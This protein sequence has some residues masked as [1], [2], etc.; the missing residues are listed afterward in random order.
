MEVECSVL[1]PLRRLFFSSSWLTW[2]FSA[3]RSCR[4]KMLNWSLKSLW[5]LCQCCATSRITWR[6]MAWCSWNREWIEAA[7][8]SFTKLLTPSV[9]LLVLPFSISVINRLL[10]TH[11]MPCVL[12]QLVDCCPWMSYTEGL[13]QLRHLLIWL[14]EAKPDWPPLFLALPGGE[15]KKYINGKWQ[16]IPVED[17]LKMTK[18]DGQVWICLYNLLLKEDCQRKYDFNSFNKNQLLKVLLNVC[19]GTTSLLHCLCVNWGKRVSGRLVSIN[20][21]KLKFPRVV[22][23][24][25]LPPI[26]RFSPPSGSIHY[27][28]ASSAV[29]L[30]PPRRALWSRCL[31]VL[32][33]RGFLTEVLIDQLPVLLEL[34]RFLAHLAITD[35]APPK[36]GLTLEL[37]HAFSAFPRMLTFDFFFI[38]M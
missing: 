12:V 21:Q 28:S 32:Q 37:V 5:R 25:M 18:L 31:S 8:Q 27:Q 14:S 30:C 34:Q 10:C 9:H 4:C 29:L 23:P 20:C 33:L 26:I 13:S 19:S 24:T 38:F 36:A 35:P 7:E 6:G 16:T 11:N 17:H 22:L 3:W 15:M 1:M 2:L